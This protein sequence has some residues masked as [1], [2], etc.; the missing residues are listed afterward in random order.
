MVFTA[1]HWTRKNTLSLQMPWDFWG[2]LQRF[3]FFLGVNLNSMPLIFPC[4]KFVNIYIWPVT[5]TMIYFCN[6]AQ[7][8]WFLSSFNTLFCGS[9]CVALNLDFQNFIIWKCNLTNKLYL[10]VAI[11]YLKRYSSTIS[12]LRSVKHFKILFPISRFY[13]LSMGVNRSFFFRFSRLSMAPS[14]GRDF[15][16]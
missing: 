10:L 16:G 3:M 2:I 1:F 8:S 6:D 13:W 4:F 14:R 15:D 7:F 5:M 9:H 11:V 12:L